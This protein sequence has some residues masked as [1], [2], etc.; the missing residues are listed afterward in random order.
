MTS[1]MS[2]IDWAKRPLQ[3]YADFSGR[4]PRAE[5]WW[6]CLFVVIAVIVVVTL[7]NLLGLGKVVLMYGPLSLVMALG[8]FVPG[9]AVQVRRLHDR[10]QPGWWLLGL[11]VPYALMLAITPTL[12]SGE[13][14]VPSLGTAAIAGILGLIVLVVAIVMLV[15]YCLPGTPGPNAYGPDPYG[16]GVDQVFA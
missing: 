5:F 4:A 9:L 16:E 14:G 12:S 15:F 1:K 8:L 6:Y 7:E 10:N 11:Y 2:P 3:K 13:G